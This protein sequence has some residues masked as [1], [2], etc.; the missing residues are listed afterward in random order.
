MT[1][2]VAFFNGFA[3]KKGDDSK[4]LPFLFFAWEE[5]N[6]TLLYGY[7]CFLKKRQWQWLLSSPFVLL[8]RKR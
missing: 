6:N 5:D 2:V 8:L 4:L 1:D 7:F 3:I